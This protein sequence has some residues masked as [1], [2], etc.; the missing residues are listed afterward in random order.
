MLSA[1]LKNLLVSLGSFFKAP[2]KLLVA[3][4]R[5]AG[6]TTVAIYGAGDLGLAVYLE[7]RTM[8]I[9]VCAWFDGK[10]SGESCHYVDTQLHNP[11]RL[12][13]LAPQ[14]LVIASEAFADEIKQ[15]CESLG[16]TGEFI[17]L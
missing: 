13:Q 14:T 15:T 2:N 5:N 4:V 17:S 10:V 8:G 12:T 3:K 11:A 6:C 16:Y 1:I 7:L 9:E